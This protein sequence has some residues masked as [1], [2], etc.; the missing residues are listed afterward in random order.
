MLIVSGR[1]VAAVTKTY[2]AAAATVTSSR[3]PQQATMVPLS[4]IDRWKETSYPKEGTWPQVYRKYDYSFKSYRN[5]QVT[6]KSSMRMRPQITVAVVLTT[7]VGCDWW[8]SF[9]L[10]LPY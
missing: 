7:V 4:I 5:P 6:I 8:L 3:K 9:H 10:P 2:C 1:H